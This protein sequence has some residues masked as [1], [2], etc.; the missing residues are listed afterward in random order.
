MLTETNATLMLRSMMT[1]CVEY[2]GKPTHVRII[3]MIVEV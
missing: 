1:L 2:P 3:L